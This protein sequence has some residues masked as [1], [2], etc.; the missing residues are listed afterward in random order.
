MQMQRV[1][2]TELSG[3][4]LSID[5]PGYYLRGPTRPNLLAPHTAVVLQLGLKCPPNLLGL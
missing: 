1:A 4:I 3:W 5:I 2:D